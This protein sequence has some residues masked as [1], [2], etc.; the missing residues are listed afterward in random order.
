[1]NGTSKT[2]LLTLLLIFVALPAVARAAES[3]NCY[4]TFYQTKDMACIDT[5]IKELPKLGGG[6][7][8]EKATVNPA[9]LGFLA[10][11]FRSYPQAKSR[12]LSQD[13]PRATKLFFAES[14]YEADLQAEAGAYCATSGLAQVIPQS[15]GRLPLKQVKPIDDP[16]DNDLLIGAY[17]ASGNTEYVRRVL[18]N[19]SSADDT[20]VT[21]SLRLSMM[22]AKF[23][24]TL[25][26]PG[27]EKTIMQAACERYECR[28]DMHDLMRAMTLSSAFWSIRSLSQRDAAISKTFTDFFE[29]DHR[30]KRLLAEES[31]AFSNYLTTLMLFAAVK[32]NP[33]INSSLSIYEKLG[34]A[35][36]AMDAMMAAASRAPDRA[37]SSGSLLEEFLFTQDGK[38]VEPIDGV[39]QLR[40]APFQIRYVGK[41]GRPS[42]FV[43]WNPDTVAQCSRLHDPLVTYSGTGLAATPS[44]LYVDAKPLTVF[45]GWNAEFEKQWGKVFEPQNVEA[46]KAYRTKLG[47][48]PLLLS[49]GRNYAN[50]WE[51]FDGTM[52]YSVDLLDDLKIASYPLNTIFLVL[53]ADKDYDLKRGRE[54]QFYSLRW[55]ALTVEFSPS[56]QAKNGWLPAPGAR[57]Q[58]IKDMVMKQVSALAEKERYFDPS[59]VKAYTESLTDSLNRNGGQ[60]ILI[61]DDGQ[62]YTK[63]IFDLDD[64]QRVTSMKAQHFAKDFGEVFEKNRVAQ[65][66]WTDLIRQFN[67]VGRASAGIRNGEFEYSYDFEK[68]SFSISTTTRQPRP[69]VQTNGAASPG[70][71]KI[72]VSEAGVSFSLPQTWPTQFHIVNGSPKSMTSASPFMINMRRDGGGAAPGTFSVISV[73][74][75]DLTQSDRFGTLLQNGKLVGAKTYGDYLQMPDHEKIEFRQVDD[76]SEAVMYGR[77]MLSLNHSPAD[78]VLPNIHIPNSMGFVGARR[79]GDVPCTTYE[80]FAVN[81]NRMTV[82]VIAVPATLFPQAQSGNGRDIAENNL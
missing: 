15:R 55:A 16:A 24:P 70:Y 50:F 60:G 76:G 46:Y 13:V 4:E 40:K 78:Q 49:S 30:L 22:Q 29:S 79:I 61:S 62:R 75:H 71:H 38:V 41:S 37:T 12:I 25:T 31:N 2:F 58:N 82:I 23:G 10:E 77:Y 69:S 17:A 21:D 73:T 11:I 53:F 66:R 80:I 27:R 39:L 7:G 19:F 67:I 14:L 65:V 43:S 54:T 26:P 18:E 42:V 51:Q 20:M 68:G 52:V 57:L 47:A 32:D 44:M 63:F 72:A 3:V 33:N 56:I 36:D 74:M 48:E 8:K 45:E 6:A 1:M 35:K 64:D 5:L 34:T 9:L 59:F 81:K 28:K